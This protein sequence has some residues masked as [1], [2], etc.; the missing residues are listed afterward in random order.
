MDTITAGP[1]EAHQPLAAPEAHHGSA[2]GEH[3]AQFL[4][5]ASPGPEGVLVEQPLQLQQSAAGLQAGAE[6]EQPQTRCAGGMVNELLRQ[7]VTREGIQAT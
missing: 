3:A 4:E 7:L 2:A 5:G 1:P 6:P